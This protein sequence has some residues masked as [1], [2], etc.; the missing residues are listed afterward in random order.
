MQS[1]E[2]STRFERLAA[3]W[4]YGGFLSAFV[5]IAFGVL[6]VGRASGAAML[7]YL[8][9]PMYQLHQYEEHDGDRFRA[10]MNG[11]VGGGHELLT[12]KAALFINVVGVWATFTLVIVGAALHHVGLGLAIVYPTL[13]NGLLHIGQAVWR[14]EYN[15]GLATSMLLFLPVSGAALWAVSRAEGVGIA[16]HLLGLIAGVGSHIAIVI[17]LRRRLARLSRQEGP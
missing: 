9:L 14:R 8:H 2:M 6:L 15:P 12:V 16:Y 13:M 11:V 5:L 3:N 7:V 4:A 1:I 10:W 17:H